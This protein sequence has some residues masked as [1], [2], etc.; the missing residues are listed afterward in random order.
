[1]TFKKENIKFVPK[2]VPKLVP[3][4]VFKQGNPMVK[5]QCMFMHNY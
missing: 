5:S 1:M 4:F 2:L 3:K